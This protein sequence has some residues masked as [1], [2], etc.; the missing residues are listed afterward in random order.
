M[1]KKGVG[2]DGTA[3][4]SS[5]YYSR[6]PNKFR[7]RTW[8]LQSHLPQ[9]RCGKKGVLQQW[10]DSLPCGSV[11]RVWT[12]V[13]SITREE[14]ESSRRP[15]GAPQMGNGREDGVGH[16]GGPPRRQKKKGSRL[17]SCKSRAVRSGLSPQG[18][19]WGP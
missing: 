9:G 12:P 16:I 10:C 18:V 15:K 2:G 19:P 11:P 1:C 14:I 17:P 13:R 4:S 6:G 5:T 8:C 3:S 7:T